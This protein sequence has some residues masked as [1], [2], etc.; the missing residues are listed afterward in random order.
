MRIG[1]VGGLDR[2]KRTFERI[3]EEAGHAV[4]VHTGDVRGRGANGLAKLVE[5]CDILFIVTDINSHGGVQHAKELARRRGLTSV[6]VRKGSV[7]NFEKIVRTLP[8][9]A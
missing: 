7:S 3:A 5:R 4:E 9:A 8:V 1:W 2:T 6:I